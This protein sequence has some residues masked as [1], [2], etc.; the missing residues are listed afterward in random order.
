MG[1]RNAESVCGNLLSLTHTC[2]CVCLSSMFEPQCTGSR[3]FRLEMLQPD[4]LQP[5]G[6]RLVSCHLLYALCVCV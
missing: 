5:E 2:V 1:V 6:W 3:K 4:I